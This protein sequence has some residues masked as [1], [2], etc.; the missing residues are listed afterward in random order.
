MTLA[1]SNVREPE[2]EGKPQKSL[3]D[4]QQVSGYIDVLNNVNL[5]TCFK[6]HFQLNIFSFVFLFI[7]I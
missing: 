7:P 3:N 1:L 2:S 6:L 4:K 5:Y